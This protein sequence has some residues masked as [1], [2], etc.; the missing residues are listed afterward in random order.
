MTKKLVGQMLAAQILSALTV[1]LCLLIDNLMIGRYLGEQALTAYGLEG[2]KAAV[3][4]QCGYHIGRFIYLIDAY[5]DYEKD[6]ETGNYNP[7][8]KKYGSAEGVEEHAEEIR[9]TLIDSMNVFSHSYALACPPVLTGMNRI[10]FNICDLGG[11][12][13]VK[14]VDQ[15]RESRTKKGS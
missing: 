9:Q 2:T 11:R 4:Q 14:R 13:A 7:F 1:S 5:D 3:A 8:L 10:V 15:E 12:E 6:A